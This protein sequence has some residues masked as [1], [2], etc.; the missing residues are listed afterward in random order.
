MATSQL[1]EALQALAHEKRID[2][3]Y[4]IDRLEKALASTYKR[5]LKLDYE[6]SVVINRDN[7]E[8]YVFEMVPIGDPDPET[9]E[10]ADYEERDVTPPDVSRLAAQKAK[11]VI[12]SIVRDAGKQAIYEE[13][14]DRVGEIVQGTVLQSTRDF[15][16]LSI[17]DGVEAELPH[18][19]KDRYPNELNEVP[20]NERYGHNQRLKV[21]IIDVRDPLDESSR[22]VEQSRPSIVVSRSHPGLIRGLFEME[23]PEIYDGLVEIKSVARDPGSRSKISVASNEY[24]LDPVGAC[25]GPKGSRV[26]MVVEELHNERVDVIQYDE[27]PVKFIE[28]ALSPAKIQSVELEE[29]TKTATVFVSDDQLSLAIGREGQNV[30]LAATLTGWKIDIKSTLFDG[31]EGAE[32]GEDLIGEVDEQCAYVNDQ[33]VRCRNHTRE[34]SKYCGIHADME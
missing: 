4:L 6:A 3:F 5:T 7:G 11:A 34:G 10:Y 28:N 32:D 19:N 1:F 21:L 9:G 25:V 22:R 14:Y 29:E 24:N 26:R 27:N 31:E 20:Y 33:G 12:K 23:V 30:R 2:E 18:F 17:R 16:I 15:T 8:I 13:F